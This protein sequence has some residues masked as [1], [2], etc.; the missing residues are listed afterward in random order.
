VWKLGQKAYGSTKKLVFYSIRKIFYPFSKSKINKVF[1]AAPESASEQIIEIK[2]RC[3]FYTPDLAVEVVKIARKGTLP[4]KTAF[5]PEPLLIL[6]HKQLKPLW[7][8]NYRGGIFKVDYL[9]N[10]DD[11]GEWHKLLNYVSDRSND[12]LLESKNRFVRR[13]EELQK[14]SLN[15]CY[16]FGTGPSLEQAINRNWSDGYRVVCNTIVRDSELWKHLDPHFIVA[17]DSIYHFG[18]TTF[19]KTFRKDLAE[20]LSES[21]AMFIYPALFHNLVIREFSNLADRLVPIPKKH[22]KKINVNLMRKFELPNLGN[23]LAVLHL[24]VACTLSNNIYLFGFDGRAPDDK[25]FWSN[26]SKHTYLEF[27]E[28]LKI[29]HPHFFKYNV[30]QN[31]PQKYI[32]EVHGDML[33]RKMTEAENEGWKFIMLHKSW[34]PMLQKRYVQE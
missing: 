31:N 19:A 34:T 30:P 28:E 20:R 33:D 13:V 29:A 8:Y 21:Q 4:L 12:Y 23:V 3:D 32:R 14:E 16:I 6:G 27:M 24:P 5:A 26:S 7:I 17:G 9:H 18:C 10:S 11:G 2:K 15:K 25:L 22:H 1:I